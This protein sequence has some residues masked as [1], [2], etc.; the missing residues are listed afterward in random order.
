[1]K[2]RYV[3]IAVIMTL[4]MLATCSCAKDTLV[5][6]SASEKN[7]TVEA[8]KAAKGDFAMTGSLEVAEGEQVVMTQHME[9]GAIL[10]E[11]YGAPA[12]QSADEIPDVEGGEP[13]MTLNADGE[14]SMSGTLPAGSYMIKVT[15]TEKATGTVQIDVTAADDK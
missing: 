7:L 13:V 6:N 8:N 2:K 5:M 15:V 12:E 4:A 9:K 11:L 10:I 14:G 1:M 3:L